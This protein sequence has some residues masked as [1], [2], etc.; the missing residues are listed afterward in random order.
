MADFDEYV[1]YLGRAAEEIPAHG[2]RPLL[3][4]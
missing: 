4:P 3:K 1:A 2:G